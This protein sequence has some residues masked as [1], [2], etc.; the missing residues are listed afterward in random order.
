M[1]AGH[2][3]KESN[4]LRFEAASVGDQPWIDVLAAINA[5][6]VN[7]L[8][9]LCLFSIADFKIE[10]CFDCLRLSYL[11]LGCSRE[12]LKTSGPILMWFEELYL[13]VLDIARTLWH[14]CFVLLNHS[15]DHLSQLIVKS[16]AKTIA[17]KFNLADLSCLCAEKI[18]SL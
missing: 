14:L 12:T 2:F 5:F 9:Q 7:Y 6:V 15:S 13:L 10:T 11:A 1:L 3:F 18:N 8:Q 17:N 4:G 16:L